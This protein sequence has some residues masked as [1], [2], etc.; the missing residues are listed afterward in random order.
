MDKTKRVS[1][2]SIQTFRECPKKFYFQYIV[3]LKKPSDGFWAFL[4][5]SIQKVLESI[6]NNRLYN[7]YNLSEIMSIYNDEST[8]I[9][10][11]CV[12]SIKDYDPNIPRDKNKIANE[13]M[14]LYKDFPVFYI[15]FNKNPLISILTKMPDVYPLIKRVYEEKLVKCNDNLKSEVEVNRVFTTKGG[16]EFKINGFIDFLYKSN[17]KYAII[18]G[19]LNYNPKFHDG[20]QLFLY[21]IAGKYKC[22]GFLYWDYTKNKL[23]PIKFDDN[24]I[25]LTYR[26]FCRTIDEIQS[27]DKQNQSEWVSIK[28][29]GCRWCPFKKECQSAENSKFE[30]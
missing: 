8:K 18:D 23:I 9:I 19:K 14:V 30:I 25:L 20:I 24:D 3:K 29:M 13:D 11:R 28:G 10:T 15:D 5:S 17:D 4:G 16:I 7:V 26:N 6:V 2:S 12:K 27:I 1:Y 22:K 21:S